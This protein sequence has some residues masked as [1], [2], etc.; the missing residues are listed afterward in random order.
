[1]TARRWQAGLKVQLCDWCGRGPAW[2]LFFCTNRSHAAH[3]YC[4][5]RDCL[6]WRDVPTR[7]G[8]DHRVRRLP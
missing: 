2:G 5:S 7:D 4:L 1:M 3:L 6:G 8:I